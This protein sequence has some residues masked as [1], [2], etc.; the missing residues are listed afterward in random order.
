MHGMNL[1]GGH[2]RQGTQQFHTYNPSD[3]GEQV[4]TYA[5]SSAEDAREAL[6]CARRALPGWHGSNIQQR[7]DIL[8]RVG[9]ALF[10]QAETMGTLLS[11]EEGKTRR[12]GVAEVQRA[13]QVFHYF[14]GEALRNPGQFMDSLRPGHGA[15]VSHE[16]VG[17]VSLITPWNFPVAVPA[18]KTAAA[19]CFGNTV[20]LK[21]SEFAPGCSVMLARAL[22][23]A[24][25]PEGVFNLVMGDGRALGEILVQGADAVSF[26]G[27]TPTGRLILQQAAVTMTKTQ[28]ELGGK[29]PLVVLD[30]ADLETAVNVALDGSFFQTGQRCT[31]SSRLIVTAGIHDAFVERLVARLNALRVGHAL[32]PD[33]DIGPVATLPQLQ[34]NLSY[35]EQARQEGAECCAG[36]HRLE[37]DT[38]GL[39]LAPTLFVNTRMDMTLNREEVFG[40]VVGVIKVNDLEEA[41]HVA[42]DCEFALSSGICTTSLRSS[43]Y[44]RRHARS[45][46]VS[47]NAPTAG[48]EYHVPFGGRKP[49]GFGG[50]ELGSTA[51]QFFTE[52]KTS[53]I[54]YGLA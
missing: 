12:E 39:F 54:N 1:I 21:P 52:S 47:V 40:P 16:P 48:V 42:L 50:R 2:W 46:M 8:R 26:T 38:D 32:A 17:V 11:R 24:G 13:A 34:K 7:A 6:D 20:V 33:T 44:F 53:Y 36:G 37:R 18:W 31:A 51:A 22:L 43:E 25:L 14:A 35:I 9:D 30:D 29:N 10:T 19:L 28:L 3:Q 15:I 4:G 23:D 27:S 5:Q 45:G 49:S 41:V